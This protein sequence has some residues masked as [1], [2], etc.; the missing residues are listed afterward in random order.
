MHIPGPYP[1]GTC[2]SMLRAGDYV[3]KLYIFHNLIGL[4]FCRE[5]EYTL[6]KIP[7]WGLRNPSWCQEEGFIIFL[8]K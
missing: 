8:R 5:L 2:L 4:L 3:H 6:K 1:Q 7:Q